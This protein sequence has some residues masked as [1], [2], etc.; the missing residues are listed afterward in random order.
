MMNG[1]ERIKRQDNLG[2]IIDRK[3]RDVSYRYEND[4]YNCKASAMCQSIPKL[5]I[6]YT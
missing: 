2:F 6:R 4:I 3:V 5:G 1:L